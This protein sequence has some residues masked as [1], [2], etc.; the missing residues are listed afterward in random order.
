MIRQMYNH[1]IHPVSVIHVRDMSTVCPDVVY[2]RSV[3]CNSSHPVAVAFTSVS[4]PKNYIREWWI[5]NPSVVSKQHPWEVRT[6]SVRCT[7]TSSV[8]FQWSSSVTCQLHV[9]YLFTQDPSYVIHHIRMKFDPMSVSCPVIHIRQRRYFKSV[10]CQKKIS[11]RGTYKIR[12]MYNDIIRP[13]S[14]IH[15]RECFVC[16]RFLFLFLFL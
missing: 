3:I 4:C 9:R 15:A 11:V 2:L 14:V 10:R 16:F 7:I 13:V 12:Q 8:Q 6:R 5:Q 1:I